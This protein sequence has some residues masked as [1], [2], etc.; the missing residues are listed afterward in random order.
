M[1]VVSDERGVCVSCRSGIRGKDSNKIFKKSIYSTKS[2]L[3]FQTVTL[4][5]HLATF[6]FLDQD[7]SSSLETPDYKMLHS[8]VHIYALHPR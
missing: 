7:L 4:S 3:Y 2:K 5:A 8:V 1:Y 6:Q